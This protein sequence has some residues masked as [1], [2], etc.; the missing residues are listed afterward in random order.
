[1][2]VVIPN[3][4]VFGDVIVNT[5]YHERRRV[6]VTFRVK[7]EADLLQVL[8]G[9]KAR[10]LVNPLVLKDPEPFTDVTGLS[11]LYAEGAVHAWVERKDYLTVRS[12]LLLAARLLVEG[13]PDAL[14]APPAPRPA[15]APAPR[16]RG[17]GGL[18]KSKR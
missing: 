14:P 11:E 9:L 4:K 2:K 7:P 5:S 18:S 13:K 10:A 16:K 17:L 1:S 6:D 12:D 8:A 15:K 3:S